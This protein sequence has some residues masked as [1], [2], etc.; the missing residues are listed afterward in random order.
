MS[1]NNNQPRNP[2]G[3]PANNQVPV[4][5]F[6]RNRAPLTTDFRNFKVRDFWNDTSADVLYYL[7]SKTGTTG[8]WIKLGGSATGDVQFLAGD[9][10]GN[11][12]PDI[13]GVINVLGGDGITT[14]GTGNSLTISA[15]DAGFVWVIV[16]TNVTA[17]DNFGG[18]IDAAGVID[19]SL[20]ATSVIGDTF[21]VVAK[22]AGGW[23]ISQLAGQSIRIGNLVTTTGVGGSVSSLAQGDWVELVCSV[24]DTEWI[25]HIN[26]G[27]I[28]VT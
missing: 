25:G 21:Q 3:Y 9:A 16:T 11:I 6:R 20:P 5:I 7:T 1:I 18:F 15:E 13:D 4:R 10:G 12:P 22:S 17:A 26:A 19:I 27:A 24:A 2:L 14:F 8:L 28:T 23:N